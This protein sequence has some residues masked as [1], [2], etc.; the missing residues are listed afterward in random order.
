MEPRHVGEQVRVRLDGDHPRHPLLAREQRRDEADAGADL[1]HAV[2]GADDGGDLARFLGLEAA[3]EHGLAIQRGDDGGVGGDD[4][5]AD[6][7][8]LLL[9]ETG[10]R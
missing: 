10:T 4:H 2:A 8:A 1:E 7:E 5:P 9:G 3:V 6:V